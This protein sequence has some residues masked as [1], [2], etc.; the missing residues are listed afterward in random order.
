MPFS[1][2]SHQRRRSAAIALLYAAITGFAAVVTSCASPETSVAP[3]RAGGSAQHDLL[4]TTASLLTLLVPAARTTPLSSDVTWSFIAGPNGAVSVNRATG[5][6][7]TIPAGALVDE[8]VI[9]VTAPAGSA[10]AYSFSPHLVF[11]RPVTL[12]Q[13]L[14]GINLLTTLTLSLSAGHFA[15][16]EPTLTANGLAVVDEVVPAY[17][18][19]LTG[20]V[21]V[22]VG[23]FSGWIIA[24]G[25]DDGSSDP[26]A[27]Q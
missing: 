18:D 4:G 5:V 17:L 21:R 12:A 2:G 14:N 22:R 6:T 27:G 15:G 3:T 1:L 16:D 19:L 26:A 10:V 13:S 7:I 24:T 11:A 8:Q 9:T 25:R 23:H 20:T